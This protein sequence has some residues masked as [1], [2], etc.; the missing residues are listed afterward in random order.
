MVKDGGCVLA[1]AHGGDESGLLLVA[2]DQDDPLSFFPELN[3]EWL[4]R[5]WS[6]GSSFWFFL[7][8]DQVELNNT[9]L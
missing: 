4:Q 6:G 1:T 5:S 9:S 7:H 8:D 2:N 3:R